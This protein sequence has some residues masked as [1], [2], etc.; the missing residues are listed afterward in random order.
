MT[1]P[2]AALW[3]RILVPVG[4]FVTYTTTM[5]RTIYWGDGIE[6]TSAAAVLGVAH[7]TGYP[8]FMLLGK[9]F[10]QLPL[11][12]IAFRVN[13]M[14]AAAATVLAALVAWIVWRLIAM[15]G[16]LAPAR[17]LARFLLAAAAGWT[18]AFSQAFWYQAGI[19]EV[20]LLN[21]TFFAGVALLVIDAIAERS[22]RSFYAACF[23]CAVGLGNH[24][25]TMFMIPGLALLAWWLTSEPKSEPP[26][27][28]KKRVTPAAAPRWKRLARLAWPSLL[29]GI[30]GLSTYA[31]LPI[32]AS[33]NPPMNW[34]DP[35]SWTRFKW[36][37]GGGEFRRNY[38]LKVPP[39]PENPVPRTY[40]QFIKDRFGEWLAWTSD[41]LLALP[42]AQ[43]GARVMIGL[44]LVAAAAA[45]GNVIR[46]G[47]GALAIWL[48]TTVALNLVATFL[49]GIPDI[50]GYWL[51]IHVF[52]VVCVFAAIAR[53]HR[54]TEERLLMRRSETLAFVFLAIPVAAWFQNR[55]LADHSRYDAPW[56]YGR[57]VLERL[58][59]NAM[60]LTMG[61][62]DIY[63]LWYQQVVERRRPDVVVFGANFLSSPWY[64]KY[65]AN[66]EPP[67][68]VRL[69]D[70]TPFDPDPEKAAGLF[71]TA[72]R[73]N[74]IEPNM[75]SRPVYATFE[76]PMLGFKTE[77]VEIPV[78]RDIN[79]YRVPERMYLQAMM[80]PYIYRLHP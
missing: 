12:T 80:K 33:A 41:Q 26:E 77:P 21:A 8:L 52:V 54:W 44:L 38:F 63:S 18:V 76:H 2:R 72:L 56:Q 62:Y 25:M 66:R 39:T 15:L 30:A 1:E 20:Y 35:S 69:L 58:P 64:A 3:L 59:R 24:T 22:A 7:P 61:D 51:P 9:A 50:D 75:K 11:G 46:R 37:V 78:L 65:F 5:A 17:V 14:S 67:V 48:G 34:G 42:S 32:R 74:I 53:L 79:T 19:T 10:A 49:Y 47:A 60:I 71:Y 23:V 29:L 28:R 6:L 73:R 45:G 57:Q 4:A 70:A 13:L 36:V 16:L 43:T 55:A 40:P 68:S 31:Y 27:K